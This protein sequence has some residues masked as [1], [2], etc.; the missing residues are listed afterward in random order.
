MAWADIVLPGTRPLGEGLPSVRFSTFLP[1]LLLCSGGASVTTSL[2][3]SCAFIEPLLC[4]CFKMPYICFSFNCHNNHMQEYIILGSW[5]VGNPLPISLS[6]SLPTI[7]SLEGHVSES[8]GKK[9]VLPPSAFKEM[10][11]KLLLC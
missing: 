11:K 1:L 3:S 10:R 9:M 5:A 6:L 8:E 2:L 7:A 4:A